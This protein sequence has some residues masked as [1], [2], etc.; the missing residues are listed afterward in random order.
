MILT[1]K[2]KEDF[3]KWIESQGY[4]L[5][6]LPTL[7]EQALII[8]FFEINNIAILIDVWDY[9]NYFAYK[10]CVKI[11]KIHINPTEKATLINRLFSKTEQ[12]NYFET[13][14]EATAKAIKKANE[15]YNSNFQKA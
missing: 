1:N 4:V 12:F 5:Y 6:G 9:E 11:H 8:R 2:T 7:F 10:S 3:L 14:Q 13:R 15:I